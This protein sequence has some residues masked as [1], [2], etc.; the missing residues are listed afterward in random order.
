M[1]WTHEF[2]NQYTEEILAM[3]LSV[4]SMN[5]KVNTM[6]NQ[7]SPQEPRNTSTDHEKPISQSMGSFDDLKARIRHHYELASEYYQA[8][9]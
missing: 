7:I 4:D 6:D 5:P 1:T 3:T 9:W 2:G 8:L